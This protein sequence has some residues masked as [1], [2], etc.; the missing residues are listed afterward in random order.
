MPRSRIPVRGALA[1]LALL[2]MLAGGCFVFTSLS[3][4][5][6][7]VV[8]G[9]S[10]AVTSLSDSVSGS[11]DSLSS[12][13]EDAAS[14]A[15]RRDVQDLAATCVAS[16]VS[17]EVFLRDLAGLAERHGVVDWEREAGT[18]RA[19]GAGLRQAGLDEP[20]MRA[21]ESDLAGVPA[22]VRAALREGYDS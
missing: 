15:Y 4:S 10:T 1:A 12:G 18:Y 6:R 17:S 16:G 7:S 14:A 8:G 22:D 2:P 5:S 20:G 3:E 9:I 13:G 21:F 11:S 19:I